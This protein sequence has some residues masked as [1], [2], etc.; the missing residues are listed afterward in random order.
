MTDWYQHMTGTAEETPR[1]HARFPGY[2][3]L[4]LGVMVTMQMLTFY[5][6][7]IPLAHMTLH[8]L[9]TPLDRMIPLIPAWVTV[10]F[11]AYVSWLISAVWILSESRAYGF[12]FAAAYLL[13]MLFSGA[14]FLLY[15]GTMERPALVGSGFFV[16]WMRF[17]YRADAPTNLCPSL[18]VLISY[19]CWRGTMG[20]KRIPGWYRRFNFVF[21]ILVCLSV[22][23]VKQHVLLDIPAAIVIGEVS[24]R[25]AGR[26]RLERIPLSLRR[27]EKEGEEGQN[28][29]A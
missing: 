5:A 7:R 15:P 14:V 18:H 23:F 8:D 27:G 25:L 13:A 2:V 1:K 28:D 29:A 22:L 6:T 10:Y 21:L 20:C 3:W 12:R 24:L 19:F 17:L 11:L 26:G 9:A 4:C 16:E